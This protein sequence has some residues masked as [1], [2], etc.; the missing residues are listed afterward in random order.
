MNEYGSITIDNRNLL[1]DLLGLG[2]ESGGQYR[3]SYTNLNNN[4]YTN[5]TN[6]NNQFNYQQPQQAPFQLEQQPQQAPFQLQQQP[7]F[8]Q[9]SNPNFEQVSNAKKVYLES[10]TF[11]KEEDDMYRF[12][13]SSLG[14]DLPSAR[15]IVLDSLDENRLK[16]DSLTAINTQINTK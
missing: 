16:E 11:L 4:G 12:V 5:N 14:T 6:Y 7:Q 1:D 8:R 10:P 15:N 13:N 2:D 3:A 9:I